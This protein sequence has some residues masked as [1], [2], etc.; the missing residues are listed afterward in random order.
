MP[1]HM[2]IPNIITLSRLPLLC[3]I[4]ILVYQSGFWPHLIAFCLLPVLFLMDWLDGYMARYMK[5]V[6]DLG[7][8]LDIAIDRVV[9][10]ALWVIFA[11]LQMV[12]VWIPLVYIVRSFVVDGLRSYALAKGHSAFGMMRSRPGRF[13]VSSRFMRDLYGG[14]KACAFGCLLLVMVLQAA[15]SVP[16]W[17]FNTVSY[18]KDILVYLSVLLCIVRGLPVLYDIQYLLGEPGRER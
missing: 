8:V 15:D 14:A 3:V 9:E 2:T 11:D 10:N 18:T 13:L 6:T 16:V 5:Q 1:V 12:P 17:F 4:L 7:S